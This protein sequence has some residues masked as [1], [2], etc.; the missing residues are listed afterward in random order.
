MNELIA[1]VSRRAILFEDPVHRPNGA[2]ILTVIQQSGMNRGGSAILE[3]FGIQYGEHAFP[4]AGTQR[5]RWYGPND[6]RRNRFRPG[7]PQQRATSVEGSPR[8][9]ERVAS[10]LYADGEGKLQGGVHQRFS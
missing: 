3:A 10:G 1:T 6:R 5:A 8:D 9:A 4:F 7:W 2:Q